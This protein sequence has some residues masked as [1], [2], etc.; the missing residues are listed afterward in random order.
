MAELEMDQS[1]SGGRMWGIISK[2]NQLAGDDQQFS[3]NIILSQGL[4][5]AYSKDSHHLP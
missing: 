3:S 5:R 4:G 2:L 1:L